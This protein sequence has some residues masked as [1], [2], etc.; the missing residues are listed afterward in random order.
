[1]VQ[2]ARVSLVEGGERFYVPER[3]LFGCDELWWSGMK[4]KG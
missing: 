2:R 4:L 3:V 1:M